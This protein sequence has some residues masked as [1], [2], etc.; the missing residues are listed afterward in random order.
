MSP[1]PAVDANGYVLSRVPYRDQDLVA[2][3]ALED[4]G[5]VPLLAR[6]ARGSRRRFGGALDHYAG[7]HLRYRPSSRGLGTLLEARR[8]PA[9]E[10]DPADLSA[11]AVRAHTAELLLVLMEEGHPTRFPFRLFAWVNDA[12]A[13]PADRQARR[14]RA[15]WV[16]ARVRVIILHQQGRL[17]DLCECTACHRPFPDGDRV[18]FSSEQGLRCAPCAA[19]APAG[20]LRGFEELRELRA[21]YSGER[22]DGAAAPGLA[23]WLTA[24][25]RDAAGRSMRSEEA[26]GRFV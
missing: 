7:V 8:M 6:G 15:A 21:L 4:E 12:L 26:L 11:F 2:R 1:A 17:P 25:V 24:R 5:V 19:D 13:E 10:P 14:A 9:A 3:L 18:H 16:L 20:A 22:Y 23:E